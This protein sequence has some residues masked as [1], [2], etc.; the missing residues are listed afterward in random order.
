MAGDGSLNQNTQNLASRKGWNEGGISAQESA[1]ATGNSKGRLS[2]PP[3][4]MGL[5]R[6]GRLVTAGIKKRKENNDIGYSPEKQ[7]PKKNPRKQRAGT[8]T[9][10]DPAVSNQFLTRTATSVPIHD[11]PDM[12]L[13]DDDSTYTFGITT[14]PTEPEGKLS[15]PKK[16]RATS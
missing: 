12:E 6:V 3:P 2:Q 4:D 8:S 16:W 5:S 14:F 11:D 7:K 10:G 15:P 13:D 9:L 1:S